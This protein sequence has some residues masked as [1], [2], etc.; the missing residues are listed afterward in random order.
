M[1]PENIML[2]KRSQASD[3]VTHYTIPFIL[4]V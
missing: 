1:N 4:N 2:R 3:K